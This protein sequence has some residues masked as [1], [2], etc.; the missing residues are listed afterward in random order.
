MRGDKNEK[1]R[2]TGLFKT[3]STALVLSLLVMVAA[4]IFVLYNASD[5]NDRAS[6]MLPFA[7][8]YGVVAALLA[9]MG[10]YLSGNL[11]NKGKRILL[12]I[13][14]FVASEVEISAGILD[15]ALFGNLSIGVS[16]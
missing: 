13:L 14:G 2:P 15:I 9:G 10:I 7:I 8:P 4:M 6:M 16:T 12:I 1:G 5:P 11:E 3:L